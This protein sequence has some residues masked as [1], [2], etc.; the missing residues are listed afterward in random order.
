MFTFMVKKIMRNKVAIKHLTSYSKRHNI[1]ILKRLF[2]LLKVITRSCT[3]KYKMINK[4][5]RC[6]LSRNI[7]LIAIVDSYSIA[8]IE[9]QG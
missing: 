1:L 5:I 2:L 7:V 4:I 6:L 8:A 3:F 9:N